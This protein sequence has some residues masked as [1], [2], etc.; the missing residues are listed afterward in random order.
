MVL[1]RMSFWKF[2]PGQMERGFTVLD[3][4]LADIARGTKGFRGNLTLLSKDDP[5]VGVVI[6]IWENEEALEASLGAVFQE[7]IKKIAQFVVSPPEVKNY[8]VFTAELRALSR[9][10]G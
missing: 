4:S 7:S 3:D 5:D 9:E 10:K 2:K 6:T 8:R 1:A